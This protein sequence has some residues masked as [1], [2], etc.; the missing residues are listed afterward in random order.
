MAEYF[1]TGKS[2][3]PQGSVAA[4]TAPHQAFRC[5]DHAY[6]AVGVV[7]EAQWPALCRALEAD[8]LLADERFSNNAG[9]VE[10][11]DE[12]ATRLGAII[13]SKA[14]RWWEIRLTQAG[15]PHGPFLDMNDCFTHI[16]YTENQHLVQVEMAHQGAI[17]AGNL[18]WRFSESTVAHKPAPF[19]GE[20]TEQ[21]LREFG[22]DPAGLLPNG[23]AK[24]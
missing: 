2:P 21:V 14:A 10:H 19:P 24:P 5:K 15:V 9:R 11:R 3:E 8:D 6:I 17:Y 16:Q 4:T 18:P 7:E 1:A 12:L 23:G 22:I 13:E 20:H